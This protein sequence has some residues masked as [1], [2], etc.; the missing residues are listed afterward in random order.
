M[1]VVETVSELRKIRATLPGPVGLVPT[2]GSLHEGHLSLI[3]R[4]RAECGGVLVSIFVNPTQFGP[5]EDFGRY[6]RDLARDLRLCEDAGADVVFVP[7]NAE[8]Y[9]PDA[10]TWVEVE[11]LQDRWEGATRPGHFRGVATVVAK[12]L[13]MALPERAYFGEKDFQQLQVVRRLAR[14]LFLDAEVV[15]CPTIRDDDGLAL[16]SRNVFLSHEA[17]FRALALSRALQE[18][19]ERLAAGETAAE[20]L[21]LAMEAVVRGTPGVDLDY[22]AVV[23]PTT[24]EPIA[25]VTGAARA[26]IAARVDS[27]HLIDNVE[28]MPPHA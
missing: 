1:R 10:S 19:Q 21:R 3:R 28:L 23:E 11:R 24:L 2:M 14:D 9:P 13:R 15:G 25:D 26:L 12:L 7:E 6:P 22:A 5:R 8:I 18:A 16:S 27:V 4:A 20:H 17:R